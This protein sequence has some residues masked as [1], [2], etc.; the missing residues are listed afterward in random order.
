MNNEQFTDKAGTTGAIHFR[1]R[2]AHALMLNEVF[3]AAQSMPKPT[4]FQPVQA[5][6]QAEAPIPQTPAS[7]LVQIT[8]KPPVQAKAVLPEQL[9]VPYNRFFERCMVGV[10]KQ[11]EAIVLNNP[12]LLK[13]AHDEIRNSSRIIKK[14]YCKQYT[15][16]SPKRNDPDR[17]DVFCDSGR[18]GRFNRAR[19]ICTQ[20][21]FFNSN[22]TP[23]VHD[24][25]AAQAND[26]RATS[27]MLASVEV[28]NP[29]GK[30]VSQHGSR[31]ANRKRMR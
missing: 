22:Y 16:P 12:T 14:R 2:A 1:Y 7:Q 20:C 10:D 4:P 25:A 17:W 21:R 9:L 28:Q 31:P 30:G 15:Y 19:A 3:L 24:T 27:A 23:E 5:P 6:L 13:D 26:W 29:P 8:P 11:E 18:N